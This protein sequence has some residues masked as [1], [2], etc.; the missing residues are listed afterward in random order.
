MQK[1]TE[2][3]YHCVGVTK[4]SFQ[5]KLLFIKMIAKLTSNITGLLLYF[6]FYQIFIITC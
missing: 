3:V 2:V 5:Q 4:E 1:D 6:L